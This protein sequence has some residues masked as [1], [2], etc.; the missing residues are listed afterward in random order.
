MLFTDAQFAIVITFVLF[1]LFFIVGYFSEKRSGGFFMLFSG[2]AFIGFDIL[3]S[4]LLSIYVSALLSPF[5][6]FIILVGLRKALIRPE[7][8]KSKSEGQ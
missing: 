2:F 7:G 1:A 3:T 6:I 4:P 5:G 8:E